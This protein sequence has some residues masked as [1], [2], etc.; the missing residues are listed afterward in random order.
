[1]PNNE[2]ENR[3]EVYEEVIISLL[4]DTV[5]T[6]KVVTLKTERSIITGVLGK[7]NLLVDEDAIYFISKYIP[8]YKLRAVISFSLDDVL[9]VENKARYVNMEPDYIN[10][11]TLLIHLR[12]FL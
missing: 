8:E 3:F 1:M 9:L 2:K 6:N 12:K 7:S 11:E 5:R 10:Y 4:N